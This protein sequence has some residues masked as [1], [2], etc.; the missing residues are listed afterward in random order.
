MG[1]LAVNAEKEGHDVLIATGDKDAMQLVT[2]RVKIISAHKDNLIFD[3]AAVRRRFDGLGPEKVV[4][5]MA[6]MGDSSDN[7]PGVKGI[8]EK[9]AIKLIQEFG[10]IERLLEHVGRI[11]SKSQQALLRE[12]AE[13]AKESKYL[14]SIDT[15]VP[16]E[17]DWEQIR[18]RP[19]DEK[20][21]AEF[22]KRYEFRTLLKELSVSSSTEEGNRAYETILTEKEFEKLL[23]KLKKA[24]AFSFDTET[25]SAD[26]VRAKLVGLS[27]SWE[28]FKAAY[29]PVAGFFSAGMSGLSLEKI[30]A[31]LRPLLEDSE[32]KK[33]GQNIKY[34]WI[35]MK[36]HGVTLQGI[37]F[38]TMIAS[39]LV[40]PLKLN[41]NLDDI[42][43]EYLGVK[44]IT[45]ASLLGSGKKQ[46]TMGEVAPEK[47][48]EYAAEDADCVFRLV[49]ILE[50]KLKE[51]GL[52]GLF[53][54]NDSADVIA[55]NKPNA[56]S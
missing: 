17:V 13:M 42:S 16:V 8:G 19:S 27:F 39:Y 44:K 11:K 37:A 20:G 31:G 28:P 43:F 54:V 25:T 5:L 24:P 33:Y 40:N 46:I 18:V 32:K 21:L 38:D 23:E 50:K 34:D 22:Y 55:A 41:H 35:V 30:I 56:A 1:T 14:A 51:H 15:Q 3:K 49:P 10:S 45:T 48:A 4:D 26:P 52:E 6:L 2:D 36:Q 9:T 7:I 47:I 12:H 29:V 53:Q